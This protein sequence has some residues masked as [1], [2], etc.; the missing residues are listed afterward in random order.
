MGI[1]KCSLTP[2]L[3]ALSNDNAWVDPALTKEGVH[4]S[5]HKAEEGVLVAFCKCNTSVK[6][7]CNFLIKL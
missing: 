5:A 4:V 2:R 7:N 1:L 6:N 3:W